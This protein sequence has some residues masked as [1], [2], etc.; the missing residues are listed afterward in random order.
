MCCSNNVQV[1]CYHPCPVQG[2]SVH[3]K[4]SERGESKSE[5][6]KESINFQMVGSGRGG[7]ANSRTASG[8]WKLVA[9]LITLTIFL[10][11]IYLER[12]QIVCFET[13]TKVITLVAKSTEQPL[14]QSKGKAHM[15]SCRGAM[16]GKCEWRSQVSRLL[17]VCF[18]LDNFFLV[19]PSSSLG[20]T[21]L[22]RLLL[23]TANT[24][25]VRD[26]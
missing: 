23:Y 17:A 10:F 22:S 14:N 21:T 19:S 13:K 20:H 15:C 26:D 7:S 8:K 4:L 25:C 18:S 11:V 1:Q 24:I 12:F 5:D 6:F 3:R 9:S 16:I 2:R